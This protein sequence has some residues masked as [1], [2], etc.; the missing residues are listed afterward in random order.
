[1]RIFRRLAA[2]VCAIG[3]AVG[4]YG[5]SVE[6]GRLV[7]RS[8]AVGV[9]AWPQSHRPLRIVLMTDLH[10]GAPHIDL[11]RMKEIVR[12]AN[13]LKPDV[14]LLGGDYVIHEV[15]GGKFVAPGPIAQALSGLSAPKGVIAV[16]GNHDWWHDGPAIRRTFEGVGIKV[17][18]NQAMAIRHG[19]QTIWIAGIADDTT[20]VPDPAGVLSRISGA[21][22]IIVLTHDPAIFA[23]VPKRAAMILAGHMHG[24]QVYLPVLGALITPGRAPRRHAYGL[25]REKGR[26]MYVSAGIGTSIIPVRLN[27]PPEIALVTVRANSSKQTQRR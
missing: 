20:R 26:V 21:D 24:G 11:A 3:L 15:V 23:D 17:L 25:I 9:A 22:P 19:G 8:V 7:V 13:A 27:M 16:L 6:P 14:V 2:L 10:V 4:I 5:V 12:R 1:M 18:E